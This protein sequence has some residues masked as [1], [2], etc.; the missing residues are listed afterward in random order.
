MTTL[1][2]LE[3]IKPPYQTTLKTGQRL[4]LWPELGQ[5]QF[6][7]ILGDLVSVQTLEIDRFLGE[8]KTQDE[9]RGPIAEIL[10]RHGRRTAETETAI[11][12][13]LSR[14]G[15]TYQFVS[16]R[17][18]SQGEWAEV[19]IYADKE[20]TEN[21][22]GAADE[23]KSWFRGDIYNI[24][25]ETL[26][27]YKAEDGESLARWEIEDALGMM[28]IS[29]SYGIKNRDIDWHTLALDSFG[30]EIEAALID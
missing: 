28:L 26:K 12:K 11:S 15:K 2:I 17:G 1:E 16:L 19:V 22:N 6:E 23:L 4:A 5:V 9:H 7:D 3:T 21:L 13:H 25:L 27:T 14:A 24:T 29:D 10:E 20:V 18:Y 30:S 8:I